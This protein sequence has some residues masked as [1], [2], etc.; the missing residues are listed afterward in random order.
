M[1]FCKLADWLR[2]IPNI[3]AANHLRYD[4]LPLFFTLVCGDKLW[5]PRDNF[6]MRGTCGADPSSA[7][8]ALPSEYNLEGSGEIM[9]GKMYTVSSREGERYFLRLLLLHCTGAKSFV[10]MRMVDGEVRG[11]FR[12]ACSRRGLLGDDA[13]VEKST[14]RII[15]F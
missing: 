13:G 9:I 7:S 5:K 2:P 15:F 8:A 10:D 11:S 14:E 6:R 12:Q 4:E 1:S 3:L